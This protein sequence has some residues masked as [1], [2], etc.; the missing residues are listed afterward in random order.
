MLGLDAGIVVGQEV[1]GGRLNFHCN[2]YVVVSG[3]CE[4]AVAVDSY[5]ASAWALDGTGNSL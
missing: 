1:V 2:L 4:Q 3:E 5:L